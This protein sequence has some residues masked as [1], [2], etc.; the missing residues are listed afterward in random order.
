MEFPSAKDL[1]KVSKNDTEKFMKELR[2]KLISK[3]KSG[4]TYCDIPNV[5]IMRDNFNEISDYL[6]ELGYLVELSGDNV[7]ISWRVEE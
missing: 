1:Y 2:E 7:C 4:Q 3:A 5:G 6:K